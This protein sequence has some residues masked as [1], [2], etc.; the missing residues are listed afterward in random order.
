MFVGFGDE[1]KVYKHY[2]ANLRFHAGYYLLWLLLLHGLLNVCGKILLSP[3]LFFPFS[4][5]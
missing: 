3:I 5:T 2:R 4:E 1:G